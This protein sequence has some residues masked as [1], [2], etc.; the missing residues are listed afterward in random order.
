M[1]TVSQ[2]DTAR[3]LT[4]LPH[5]SVGAPCPMVVAGEHTLHLAYYL[6]N[7]PSDWDGTSVRLLSDDDADE[8]CALVTFDGAYAH[9][10]GPPND[11]AFAGHPLA[12]RGLRP[13]AAFEVSPS[14]WLHQLER[15]NSV[16]PHHQAQRFAHYK[17]FVFAFHDATFE[18]IA[19]GFSVSITQGSVWSV[20][21]SQAREA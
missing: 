4:E 6:E 17:H 15:M 5:S 12:S 8:P 13:Y 7:R 2:S 18:C 16:H 21:S 11:E 19:K 14:S 1:Y 9:M 3:E 10:F 20:L